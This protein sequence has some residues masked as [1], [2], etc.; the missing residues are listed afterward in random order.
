MSS[1]ISMFNSLKTAKDDESSM[2][3]YWPLSSKE[4]RIVF[5][6]ILLKFQNSA[7]IPT[8]RQLL[9]FITSGNMIILIHSAVSE[10]AYN[11]Y[12][13][14][15]IKVDVIGFLVKLDINLEDEEKRCIHED[16]GAF[17]KG[18]I[19]SMI[20]TVMLS[21]AKTNNSDA[22]FTRIQSMCKQSGVL[23]S[24]IMTTFYQLIRQ[25]AVNMMLDMN[26]VD[27]IETYHNALWEYS[28]FA[29]ASINAFLSLKS[30]DNMGQYAISQVLMVFDYSQMTFIKNIK[31][32]MITTNTSIR[33]HRPTVME[34]VKLLKAL[35]ALSTANPGIAERHF[36]LLRVPGCDTL[37][38]TR[39]P[40][41]SAVV[42]IL[43]QK[44]ASS[45]GK[46]YNIKTK[47]T[48]LEDVNAQMALVLPERYAKSQSILTSEEQQ[49]VNLHEIM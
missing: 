4:C 27:P 39:Y 18:V 2:I 35:T 25:Q 6:N 19:W 29:R 12:L 16:D 24:P 21:Y 41:L 10:N 7:M 32:H 38:S 1:S 33:A 43:L 31:D 3:G 9:P 26:I 15:K 17:S 20:M 28:D 36:K 5:K 37:D 49:A 8:N 47:A 11:Q 42:S 13:G 48:Y 44:S 22:C 14:N 40:R 30:D 23:V 45:V 34:F 46:K